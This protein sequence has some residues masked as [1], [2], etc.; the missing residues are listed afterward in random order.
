M[1]L[2]VKDIK[3]SR[4][5]LFSE[6]YEYHG[7]FVKDD[8]YYT[9]GKKR[10]KKTVNGIEG[11]PHSD[12]GFV[13]VLVPRLV[14][15]SRPRNALGMLCSASVGDGLGVVLVRDSDNVT[16]LQLSPIACQCLHEAVGERCSSPQPCPHVVSDADLGKLVH[17]RIDRWSRRSRKCL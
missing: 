6:V 16:K 1:N 17:S 5:Y 3:W 4:F 15:I 9:K 10:D 7:L 2:R 12:N 13:I 14:H 8:K 11:T